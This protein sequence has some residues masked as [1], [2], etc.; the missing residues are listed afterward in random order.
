MSGLVFR[1][2]LPATRSHI[3]PTLQNQN[4]GEAIHDLAATFDGHLRIPEN[5]VGLGRGKAF[6]AQMDGQLEFL[7]KL[8]GEELHFVGLYSLGAAHTQRI[9][10][11]D[12]GHVVF[13][14]DLL[15]LPK[16]QALVLPAHGGEPL[17]GDSEQVRNRHADGL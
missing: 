9:S 13:A 10:H 2:P 11:D 1:V 5:A 4:G 16:I 7:V 12:F 17:G 6:V 15:E 14:D 8:F 3:H